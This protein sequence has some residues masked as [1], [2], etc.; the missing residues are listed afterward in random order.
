MISE[1]IVVG[2]GTE[3]PLN[4]LLTLPDKPD[5]PVPA[6][7]LVHGSGPSNM[8][9]TVKKLTPF[10]D[11]AEG[12]ARYGVAAL[13]YDKRTF[14]HAKKLVK[15]SPTAKE[16]TID[17][18]ILAVALAK[19]DP[20]IDPERV[21]LLGH[22]LGAMLAPRIDA[23]GADAKGLILL[24]GSP[25]RLEEIMLRQ[26]RQS[27]G[28][29]GLLSWIVGLELKIF[30]KKFDGLYEMSDE[31]A[32][33][34]KFAG[35]LN[36]YYFKEMGQKTAAD[37]LL[38]SGKPALILQG[39]RDFQVLADDDFRQFRTLLAG[40]ADTQFKLYPELNHLFVQAQYDDI[41]KASQEYSVERHIGDEVIGDIA[42]FVLAH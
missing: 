14:A 15:V 29:K 13:R 40:R 20:R 33:K 4:G 25:C 8:D 18:A 9:E 10:R 36:L 6:V 28:R 32:K 1:K 21:F 39:G 19:A 38:E 2:A 31:E 5:T 37:Y 30:G 34:K 17:D 23:E 7:V 27:C 12:L 3:Y 42:A 22:S 26:L 24:A 16:E 35:S 41:L 11:L